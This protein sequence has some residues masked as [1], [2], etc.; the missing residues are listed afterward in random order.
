MISQSAEYALRAVVC[1]AEEP[2]ALMSTARV[3]EV[4]KVP[5]GYLSKVLQGLARAGLVVSLPGRA[6][7]FRLT[8]P[9]AKISLL[10]VVNAV[11]PVK[12]IEK[13]PLGLDSH[14]TELCPL[15]RRLDEAAAAIERAFADT[16]IAEVLADPASVR[17]LCE[18]DEGKPKAAS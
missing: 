2:E 9:A 1:L 17:A 5:A 4:T 8:R 16:T 11:D 14:R 7:G 3:A 10:D 15:H 6:G 12:R 13:C 18:T